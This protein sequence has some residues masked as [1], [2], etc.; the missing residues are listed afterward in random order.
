MQAKLKQEYEDLIVENGFNIDLIIKE[1]RDQIR[2][3]QTIKARL[4]SKIFTCFIS[5][6]CLKYNLAQNS[7]QNP[8]ENNSSELK[9]MLDY[10][11]ELMT[12]YQGEVLAS[13]LMSEEFDDDC[14]NEY[15]EWTFCYVFYNPDAQKK[16]KLIHKQKAFESI[17][18]LF[19]PTPHANEIQKIKLQEAHEQ[20]IREVS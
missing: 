7:E 4:S 12:A 18:E 10:K 16:E 15:W 11:A 19:R 3:K 20:A 13:E 1:A 2:K 14:N 9:S 8:E 17:S 5:Y 6:L